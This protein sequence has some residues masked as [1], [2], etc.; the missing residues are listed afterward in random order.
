MS[1]GPDIEGTYRIEKDPLVAFGC[2]ND[3]ASNLR[4]VRLAG[5]HRKYISLGFR[6]ERY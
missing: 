6:T 2:A 5:D 3:L 4:S 1:L